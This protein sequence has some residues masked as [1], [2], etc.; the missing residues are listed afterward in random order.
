[1]TVKAIERPLPEHVDDLEDVEVVRASAPRAA[2]MISKTEDMEEMDEY[3][4]YS[5]PF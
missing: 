2:V 1:M 5:P 4:D 3:V